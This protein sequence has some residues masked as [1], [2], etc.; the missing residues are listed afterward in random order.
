MFRQLYLV[1]IVCFALLA[2]TFLSTCACVRACVRA[3]VSVCVRLLQICMSLLRQTSLT[4]INGKYQK[5][6]LMSTE[7]EIKMSHKDNNCH[8]SYLNTSIP[9]RI[10][11]SYGMSDVVLLGVIL[12]KLK[13]KKSRHPV[14]PNSLFRP[15]TKDILISRTTKI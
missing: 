5:Y 3:C 10:I 15:R 14:R 7:A 2:W 1:R 6:S 9:L 13:H 12:I 8:L 4:R 11:L